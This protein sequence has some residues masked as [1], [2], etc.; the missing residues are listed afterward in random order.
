ML[1]PT[2]PDQTQFDILPTDPEDRRL[3]LEMTQPVVQAGN[4]MLGEGHV[5]AQLVADGD[6]G[7]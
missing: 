1:V 2:M 5:D 6:R 4:A 3:F 7:G